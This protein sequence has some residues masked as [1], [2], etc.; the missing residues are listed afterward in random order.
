MID[1]ILMHNGFET[2]LIIMFGVFFEIILLFLFLSFMPLG[3]T[4]R[5]KLSSSEL[6]VI[7]A[8]IYLDLRALDE[9]QKYSIKS[10]S[11][12]SYFPWINS[13]NVMVIN[14]SNNGKKY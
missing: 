1:N 9:E 5:T 7:A 6:A 3:K 13:K 12:S 11:K 2:A 10:V 14:N 8:G 4:E